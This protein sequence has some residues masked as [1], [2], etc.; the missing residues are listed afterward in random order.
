MGAFHARRPLTGSRPPGVV[1]DVVVRC[2]GRSPW[3]SGRSWHAGV[4][5]PLSDVGGPEGQT[6]LLVLGGCDDSGS[7]LSDVWLFTPATKTWALLP[8]R[9]EPLRRLVVSCP[10]S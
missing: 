1:P 2:V 7:A 6:G 9:D 8:V 5:V 4:A 3:P 10:V